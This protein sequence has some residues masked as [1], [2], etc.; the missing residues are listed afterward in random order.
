MHSI[1]TNLKSSPN[2]MINRQDL[3]GFQPSVSLTWS[4]NEVITIEDDG[5]FRILHDLN[6]IYKGISHFKR[7]F[8]YIQIFYADVIFETDNNGI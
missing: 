7:E 2:L 3:K 1:L 8:F 4:R 5:Y 6:R